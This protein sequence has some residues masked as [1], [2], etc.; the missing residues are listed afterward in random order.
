MALPYIGARVR[1]PEFPEGLEWLNAGRPLTMAELRGKV[2]LLDF[3]TFCCINCMHVLPDLKTLERKYPRELAVI[4]V[5]SAKF[6]NEKDAD[7]IRQ[8][9]LRYE[10]EHPVVNDQEFGVWRAYGVRAWPTLVVIGPDGYVHSATSGEGHL[11]DLDETVALLADRVRREN[12]L[13]EAPLD[14]RLARKFHIGDRWT[15]DWIMEG[16]NLLNRT[17]FKEVNRTVGSFVFPFP[18]FHVSG[19]KG[20]PSTEFL[21]FT[22]A[23]NP[24]QF[25][26]AVKFNF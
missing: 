17:N 9:I 25:Q 13:N 11:E 19:I 1:A 10:I 21:G 14:L 24:L 5:H 3:W 26:L 23:F 6:T 8:A 20:R 7:Q 18:T 12:R 4:G 15:V 22:E 16:F 2:V